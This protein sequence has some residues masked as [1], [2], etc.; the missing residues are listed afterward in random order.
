M[1]MFALALVL[2]AVA[3]CG[4]GDDGTIVA[5]TEV[6]A[7]SEDATTEAP[8][9]PPSAEQVTISV[10]YANGKLE[11]GIKSLKVK[12]GTHVVVDVTS[13]VEDEVHVHGPNI[14]RDVGPGRPV[15]LRFRATIPGRFEAEL[16]DRGLQIADI[17]VKP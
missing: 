8:A 17:T 9:T 4:D 3:G 6:P 15:R 1:R 12:K 7:T 5:T 13:D 2:L 10:A 11:G 14:M 16:E